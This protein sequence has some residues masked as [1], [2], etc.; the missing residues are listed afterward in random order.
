MLCSNKIVCVRGR[1]I[2]DSRGNPTVEATVI[3]EDGSRGV[4]AVP[5]GASTG[6]HEACELRD[7]DMSRFGGRGVLRA[8]DNI[9]TRLAS[10]LCG[11]V[12]NQGMV[13]CVILSEDGTDNKSGLGA[14]A[15][16]AVSLAAAKAGACHAHIPLYRYIGGVSGVRLPIPMMNILNGGAHA[17]NNL[18]I[19]EF[20]IVPEGFESYS[21]ALRAGCEVYAALT[22]I[23]KRDGH[24]S[25]VGDEGGC[26][27]NLSGERE[28]LDYIMRA[29][30]EAHYSSKQIKI[31][32]DCAA[33]EWTCDGGYCL[34]K[35]GERAS[36]AALTDKLE[37]L[38][39]DY[40]IVSVEDGLGEDDSE[41]WREMTR[42]LGARVLLVGD[43]LFATNPARVRHG[44][45]NGM[46]NAV[47]IKPNQI[48]TLSETLEV[49]RISSRSGY[50][51]ILSH[52][53]GE[54]CDTSIADIAVAVNCGYI[55]TGAPCRGERTAKYNRLL[56]IEG[57]LACSA[58]FGL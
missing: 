30:E 5:S 9:N 48:G 26:A 23:L 58:R 40:P 32:L 13:D 4:A 41:G 12:C 10:R 1:E 27:P 8:V 44:I 11:M 29:I 39:K 38:I 21:E 7:G 33:S 46:A 43:D 25:S 49:V 55:K 16:L 34:P 45:E 22:G 28:A 37:A 20:M 42:R 14:N 53:S 19:Q 2:I 36:S 51:R 56:E 31:A 47:L 18:D 50:E 57:E 52:R 17:A 15:T 6:S 35:C 54:T 24:S 3:L